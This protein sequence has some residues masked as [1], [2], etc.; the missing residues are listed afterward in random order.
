[1]PS[2]AG[3]GRFITFEGGEGVGKS[4]QIARV[5]DR[6]RA[7]GIDVVETREPGGTEG[8]EH[9]R[10]LLVSGPADRWDP[11]AELLLIGSAR[12]DHVRRV[13]APALS[14]GT[15]VL[16]DRFVDSTR[17]YQ[18]VAGGVAPETVQAVNRIATGGLQPDVTV[19]LDIDPTVGLARARAR[20]HGDARYEGL[21]T[22]FHRTV[23]RAFADIAAAEPQRCVLLDAARPADDVTEAVANSLR[24]RV[25]AP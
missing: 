18:G 3:R 20:D 10:S 2:A 9:I 15:W 25:G 22:D 17:V 23:R 7:A 14:A 11:V 12:R 8:A 5:A 24:D 6:L 1:M 4:T 16:C 19:I 21:D 13:I